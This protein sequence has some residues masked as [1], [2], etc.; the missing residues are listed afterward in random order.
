M[1]GKLFKYDFQWINK[2]SCV[3]FV[4][5]VLVS[6]AT[7][8]VES[9]DQTLFLVIVDKILSSMFIGCAVSTLI[10][11]IM[12]VWIRFINSVYKDESYL[13]HTLPVTKNQIFSSKV[14]S[15]I[16]SLIVS[17]LVIVVCFSFVYLRKETIDSFR[18]MWQSLVEAY[19]GVF[20]V[21]FVVGIVLLISLETIY[22]MMSGIFGIVIGYR[23][24]NFKTIK[25]IVAGI[26]SYSLLSA[27]SFIIVFLVSK[28]IDYDIIGNGFPTM[29][30]ISIL[31]LLSLIIYF[32]YD[33]IYYFLAK[34]LLNKGV[35]V[36]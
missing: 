31:G 7:R 12:R 16:V 3:Y 29:N 35:N 6:F 34:K 28:S 9:I 24:N 36:E 4:L 19:N 15:G 30:Y 26:G 25:A 27:M 21:C 13:T 17:V 18:I 8:I 23:S 33:A 32:M 1:L 22:L 14:L 20:A 5:L 11:C 2:A 10:T